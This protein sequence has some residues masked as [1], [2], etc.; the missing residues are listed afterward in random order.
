MVISPLVVVAA[1]TMN[2][3]RLRRLGAVVGTVGLVGLLAFACEVV[4]TWRSGYGDM[5][6][7]TVGRRFVYLLATRTEVPVVQCVLAGVALLIASAFVK[8]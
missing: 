3:R 6:A 5:T 4:L 8:R 7:G 1:R 2:P